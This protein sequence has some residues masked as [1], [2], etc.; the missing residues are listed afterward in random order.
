M[1]IM[2]ENTSTEADAEAG[3]TTVHEIHAKEAHRKYKL[4]ALDDTEME[5]T[6]SELF[7]GSRLLQNRDLWIANFRAT[8][9]T[10]RTWGDQ[11]Q[12][13]VQMVLLDFRHTKVTFFFVPRS[14]RYDIELGNHM[15]DLE[16]HLNG[17][18][19]IG[20]IET[21]QVPVRSLECFAGA[22]AVTVWP[23]ETAEG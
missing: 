17:S 22:N 10:V 3:R 2:S 4:I 1:D 23:A 18:A 13:T 11:H 5:R 19:G 12:A 7:A 21:L 8:I 16:V 6:A 15:T 20:Y 14:E 9:K